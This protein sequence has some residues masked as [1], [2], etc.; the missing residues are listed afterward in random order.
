MARQGS[1]FGGALLLTGSCIGAGMLGLPIVTGL[2]GF[3]PSTAMFIVVWIFVTG[4]SFLMVEVL[5]WFK[6]PVNLISMVSDTLGPIGQALCWLLYLFLFYAILVAYMVLSGDHVASFF[7]TTFSLSLPDWAGSCFFVLIFGVIVYFGTQPVDHLNRLLMVGKIL[8]YLLLVVCSVRF[9]SA[10]MLL[11]SKPKYMIASLPILVI[12]FGFQNMIPVLMRYMGGDRK[13]VRLSIVIGSSFALIIYL[14]WQWIALGILPIQDILSSYR[15]DKDAA[16][17]LRY[18]VGS[19]WIGY[20][21]QILAFFAI[22][23]SFL[24]Q[25]LSLVHFLSD[26]LKIKHRQRENIGI[27]LLTLVPPL[28]FSV[29]FPN[30]F[31]QALG[32]AGGICAV[33]LFGIFPVLM[34][35]IG[36]YQ[37]KQ[38]LPDR[39]PGGKAVLIAILLLAGLIFFYQLTK[40]IGIPLF[41]GPTAATR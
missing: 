31:F 1:V 6:K 5:G 11:Y 17:T 25:S 19:D 18:F 13:R 28:L 32:F 26:G 8:A 10:K 15:A 40:M 20:S 27:C 22:L 37:R 38:L 14:I 41:P 34:A 36:R 33:V 4:G 24:A 21:A 29:F 16:L 23:T 2:A 12:A 35:W 39:L 9:V 30:I 3:F 7:K